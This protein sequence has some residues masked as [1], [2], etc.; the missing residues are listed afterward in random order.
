MSDITQ[1]RTAEE[2]QRVLVAELQ[3]R[4]RN[5]LGMIRALAH[6]TA[7]GSADLADFRIRFDDRLEAFARIQGLL[8]RLGEQDRVTFD[9][10]LHSELAAVDGLSDRV[11]LD[12]P[13]SV[14]LRSSTVQVLALAL[15]ELVTNAVKHGALGQPQARLE[16][17]WKCE[18]ANSGGRP[19]LHIDWRE[20]GVRMPPPR[21]PSQGRELIERALPY[22]LDARTT[23]ALTE[24]GVHCTISVP[25]SSLTEAA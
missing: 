8:S 9:E 4:T 10:L 25:V 11:R 12:G 24:D 6:K 23:F 13:S 19:W 14:R 17:T 22:Q 21:P 1:R 2:T 16:V 3:H 18:P 15:H 20:T 5:L 7:E